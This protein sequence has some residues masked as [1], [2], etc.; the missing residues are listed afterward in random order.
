MATKT[1]AA[2]NPV[3]RIAA[4]TSELSRLREQADLVRSAPRALAEAIA[5]IPAVVEA[6]AAR[7]DPPVGYLAT[8]GGGGDLAHALS[9]NSPDW[10]Q[11]TPMAVF[12]W[13]QPEA[14][15]GAIERDLIR[16]YEE[17]PTP[18]AGT[19]RADVL[20]R[21]K[22]E[23]G[24]IEAEIAS[25]WWGAIDAGMPLPPPDIPAATLI[26]LPAS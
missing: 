5:D 24:R 19:A 6:L 3:D 20:A 16:A 9:A 26:G 14:L 1:K 12:A 17:L 2:S 18:M 10:P 23:I 22:T 11:L 4:L 7:V 8:P 13:V 21:L 15:A 25:A